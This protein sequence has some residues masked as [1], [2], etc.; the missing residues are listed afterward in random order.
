[1]NLEQQ[2]AILTI[3]LYE[4]FADGIKD[5]RERAQI[6]QLAESLASEG[7]AANLV[8]IYQ[9]VLLKRVSLETAATMLQDAGQ[10]QLAYEMAVC[11][12]D[13]DGRQNADES[14]F[15][16]QLN[17]LLDL[18]AGQAR[19]FER[20]A[21]A[22][23]ELSEAAVP[24]AVVAAQPN[25]SEA[26]LD[27]SILNYSL[28]NGALELLP[29]SWALMATSRCRSRW[30]TLSAVLTAGRWTR[31]ISRNSSLPPGWGSLRN[32]CRKSGSRPKRWTWAA[33]WPWC[34]AADTATV[35]A[36]QKK[37]PQGRLRG[38]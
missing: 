29:Q 12:C 15:L 1:M 23:V 28:L 11:V 30:S 26:E 3:A 6:R 33:S 14:R 38:R 37:A 32:T 22:V 34:A 10:R 21:D 17:A 4:T 18:D 31:A 25:V 35:I 5:D 27:Q 13:A 8:G 9:D 20:D 24:A 16:Q 2:R 7:G 36:T 19:A